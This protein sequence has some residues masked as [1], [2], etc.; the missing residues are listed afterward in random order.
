MKNQLRFKNYCHSKTEDFKE[1]YFLFQY[2]SFRIMNIGC[3]SIN[4]LFVKKKKKVKHEETSV[5]V[6]LAS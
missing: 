2:T 1:T 5:F 4:K 6:F 3:V